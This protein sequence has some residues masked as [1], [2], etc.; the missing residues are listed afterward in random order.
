MIGSTFTD[1]KP[2]Q[3]S[4]F[5]C[6]FSESR[7]MHSLTAHETSGIDTWK[8][9]LLEDILGHLPTHE[10]QGHA[11][12]DSHWLLCRRKAKQNLPFGL[13]A[14]LFFREMGLYLS[15]PQRLSQGRTAKWLW[16]Q[17]PW[18]TIVPIC[19]LEALCTWVCSQVTRDRKFQ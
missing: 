7:L 2:R 18:N 17:C 3:R 14:I 5:I 12:S 15:W 9:C 1:L 8:A 6:L 16:S 10:A 19:Y 13:P 11:K 4:V